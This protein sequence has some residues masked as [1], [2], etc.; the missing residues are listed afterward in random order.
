MHAAAALLAEAIAY[1]ECCT[2]VFCLHQQPAIQA[3][4]Q[5]VNPRLSAVFKKVEGKC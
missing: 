5:S 4:A 1:I 2:Y 3:V